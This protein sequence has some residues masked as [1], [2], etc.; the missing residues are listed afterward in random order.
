[1]SDSMFRNQVSQGKQAAERI[2]KF[3]GIIYQMIEVKAL[4]VVFL[5]MEN[6]IQGTKTTSAGATTAALCW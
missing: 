3:I 1:M 4:G 5:T 6:R 2:P